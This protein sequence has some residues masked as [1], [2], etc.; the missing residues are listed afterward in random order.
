ME[1]LSFVIPCYGSELTIE[2]VLDEIH[3]VMAQKPGIDYE[4]ICVNDSSPDGV[5]EVLHKRLKSDAKLIVADL[6][7]NVGKASA[8][9]AGYAF[10]SGDYV[11]NLDDDGQCP[12]DKLW[13]LVEPT[14][15]ESDVSFAYYTEKRQSLL[16]KMGSEINSIMS[17]YIV[18]KPRNLRTSNFFVVKRFVAEEMKKQKSKF[19]Y[20]SGIILKTT[21]KITNVYMKERERTEGRGSFTLKKSI[22]LLMNGFTAFSVTPLRL[23][24]LLGAIVALTGFAYGF[25]II[26]RRLFINP[27]MAMGFPSLMSA[28]LLI[29][30]LILLMLGMLGEYVG[31]IYIDQSNLPQY[32]I[33]A[34]YLGD[35]TLKEAEKFAKNTC[36]RRRE[37]ANRCVELSSRQR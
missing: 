35:T 26:L 25:F 37:C 11:A 16:K 13:D 21:C 4:I 18:G 28:I 2:G 8:V 31:R 17:H 24:S 30:G 34:V 14:L 9:L 32:V 19:P 7:K 10:V 3:E 12:L 36:S 1:K 23:S 20:L 33:K 27:Y 29:G 6:A 15:G 22:I 5:L